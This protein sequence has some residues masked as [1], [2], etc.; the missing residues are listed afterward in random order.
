VSPRKS[1]TSSANQL[2]RPRYLGLEVAGPSRFLPS[3]RWWEETL[4]ARLAAAV[5]G[6]VQLRVIRIEARRAI[7]EIDHRVTPAARGAWNGAVTSPAGEPWQL[8]TQ[9]TWGTLVG[10]K[11]WLR[12]PSRPRSPSG[13]GGGF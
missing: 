2:F 3:A 4:R 9:Q 12:Q 6:S 8:T 1:S 11:A 5:G 10:A 13:V 7:V